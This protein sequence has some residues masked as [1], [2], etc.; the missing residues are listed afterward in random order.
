LKTQVGNE[1]TTLCEIC[2]QEISRISNF[3]NEM[4]KIDFGERLRE[5]FGGARDIEIA[6]LLGI[7]PSAVYNYMNGRIPEIP[8]LIRI[9]EITGRDIHWLITGEV[10]QPVKSPPPRRPLVDESVLI[11]IIREAVRD[12]I[13]RLVKP[14]FD[15]DVEIAAGFSDEEIIRHW[16]QSEGK[17]PPP[18]FMGIIG[19]M[20]QPDPESRRNMLQDLKLLLDKHIVKR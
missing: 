3:F 4:G 2:Q 20:G 14:S 11:E 1:I 8:I 7:S 6:R 17:E 15:L 12:E 16:Y 19:A 9:S 13:S 5:A 18:D 10:S